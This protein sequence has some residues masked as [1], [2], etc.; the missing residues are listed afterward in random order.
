MVTGRSIMKVIFLTL[1]FRDLFKNFFFFRICYNDDLKVIRQAVSL[2]KINHWL[3][4]AS[5]G[6][7]EPNNTNFH[8]VENSAKI[9]QFSI[10]PNPPTSH[11][12]RY[13]AFFCFLSSCDAI[14]SS[15][16]TPS[17]ADGIHLGTFVPP[18]NTL[19]QILETPQHQKYQTPRAVNCLKSFQC[20]YCLF[21]ISKIQ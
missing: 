3:Q 14:I 4:V 18:K 5:G 19:D 9:C 6:W 11:A 16:Q 15:F 21:L 1:R 13:L 8:F 17:R 12:S 10:G 2:W 7:L 20:F